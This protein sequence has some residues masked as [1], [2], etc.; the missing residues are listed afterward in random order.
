[1]RLVFF[2]LLLSFS[3]IVNAENIN[4]NVVID[5]DYTLI[6]C[7]QWNDENWVVFDST[8]PYQ[9]LKWWIEKTIEYINSNINISGNENIVSWKIF[10]IKVNCSTNNILDT[11]IVLWFKWTY[12][13][14]E[15]LI[16]WIWDNWLII[17]KTKFILLNWWWW[18]IFKNAKFL[19][20]YIDYFED[21]PDLYGHPNSNWITIKDSYISLNN[22]INF[23]LT[24]TYNT[25]YWS[26]YAWHY[27]TYTNYENKQK[28]LNS[29]IEINLDW[30]YDFKI[31]FYLKD[32]QINF[33]NNSNTWI[34]DISFNEDWNIYNLPKV[35]YWIFVSNEIDFWWN[36]INVENN[37]DIWFI[38][39]KFANFNNFDLW[40]DAM[41]FNNTFENISDI[42]ITSSHY[43]LNNVFK[44]K[45][46]DTYDK[47]NLRKNYQNNEIWEKWI[48]WIFKIKNTND[49]FNIDLSSNKL[50]KEI[51]GIDIEW[52][53]NSIYVIFSK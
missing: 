31:P 18:I 44:N 28:I 36:N 5:N 45:F 39:N 38:N 6:D 7:I 35:D 43:L 20:E 12:Y 50:Y 1:M 9:T 29:K 34:Y 15:L 41:F 33:K 11:N 26:D 14:N 19:N 22:N 52:L 8:K 10:N 51:T 3:V 21:K 53:Y 24:N 48:W 13:D 23:W 37:S 4:D 32:S 16:E 2:V 27:V 17:Q 46:I 49:F 47:Y 40:W 42:D 30:N 25:R